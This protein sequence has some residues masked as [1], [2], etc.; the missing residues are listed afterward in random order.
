MTMMLILVLIAVPMVV[1]CYLHREALAPMAWWVVAKIVSIRPIAD[2]LIRRAMKTPYTHLPGY[3]N[4]YWLFNA[5]SKVNGKETTPIHWLPSIRIHHILRRDQDRHKHDHPW[6]ARTIILKDFYLETKVMQYGHLKAGPREGT[7]FEV[8]D[9]FKRGQGDTS[10]ILFGDYHSITHV[11]E[12][13]VWT[14]FI[15]FGYQGTWGFL[16]DGVKVP[17]YEYMEAHPDKPWASDEVTI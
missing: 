16:V 17:W 5:Y 8:T 7:Y 12:G 9:T 2:Y 3:M 13:G 11:P 10:P 6:N 4:R 1:S 14:L 15:T